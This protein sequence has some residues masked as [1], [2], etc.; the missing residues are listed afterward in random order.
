MLALQ[1]VKIATIPMLKSNEGSGIIRV[2]I[3]LCQFVFS[4]GGTQII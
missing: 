4:T 2:H 1:S 3:F